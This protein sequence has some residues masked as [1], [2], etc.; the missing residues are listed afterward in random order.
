MDR[1]FRQ[2]YLEITSPSEPFTSPF[3][4]VVRAVKLFVA[5]FGMIAA[6]TLAVFLPGNLALQFV[7]EVLDIPVN[8]LAFYV[9][10]EAVDLV[11]ASLVTPAVVYALAGGSSGF[12]PA[13]RWGR[14]QFGKTLWNEVKV[15]IT[16]ILWGALLIVPG[17][18]ALIRLIFTDVIVAVEADLESDPMQRSRELS[19]GRLWRMFAVLAPIALL[20]MAAMFLILDRPGIVES[21]VLFAAADSVLNIFGQLTTVA[22]LL[23]YLGLVPPKQK[24]GARRAA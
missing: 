14:R 12:G 10:M 8:G 5:R 6:I 21:R 9:L 23:M 18:I 4:L 1:A 11:L 20:N 13:I 7:C 19:K 17:V 16:V 2:G 3:G 15:N 24:A 22:V